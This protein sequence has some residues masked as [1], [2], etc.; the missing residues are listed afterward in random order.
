M[1]GCGG[2]KSKAMPQKAVVKSGTRKSYTP[3]SGSIQGYAGFGKPK[4]KLSFGKR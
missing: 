4:V 3:A 1:G 2:S